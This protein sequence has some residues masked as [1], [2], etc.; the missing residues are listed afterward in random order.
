VLDSTVDAGATLIPAKPT[1]NASVQRAEVFAFM[2]AD[3]HVPDLNHQ[4]GLG[5]HQL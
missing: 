2:A 4:I 1:L 3:D 5:D